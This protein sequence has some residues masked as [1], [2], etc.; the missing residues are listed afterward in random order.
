[1]RRVPDGALLFVSAARGVGA[2]RVHE[3]PRAEA[4]V[5]EPGWERRFLAEIARERDHLQVERGRGQ[6]SG[7]IKRVVAAAVIDIDD[8][9]GEAALCRELAR[10]LGEARVK[11]REALG[12]VV[13]RHD[14]GKAG[15]HGGLI[16]SAPRRV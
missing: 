13:E 12:L 10:D 8:L 5:V 15:G 9:D 16:Y 3:Q 1:M 11:R 4:G 14:D 6:R 7:K 2:L